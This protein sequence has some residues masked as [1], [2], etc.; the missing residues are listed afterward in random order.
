MKVHGEEYPE[1]VTE[2]NFS[3]N[4][5]NGLMTAVITR[6]VVVIEGQGTVYQRTQSRTGITYSKNGN[7]VTEHVWNS[8]TQGPHLVNHSK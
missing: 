2:E 7:P 8:E 6:R 3:Q 5:Q 1:G 4:D